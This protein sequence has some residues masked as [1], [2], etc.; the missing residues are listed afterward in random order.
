MTTTEIAPGAV[1]QDTLRRLIEPELERWKVPGIEV[2]LVKDDEVVF[3]GGFAYF[4]YW[5]T[6][7]LREQI[8]I[9]DKIDEQTERLTEELRSL[10]S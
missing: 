1:D 5:L 7:I 3:A 2:A 10:R 6:C 4:G 9:V 8:R